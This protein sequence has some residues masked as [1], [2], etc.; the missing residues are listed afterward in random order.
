MEPLA[1]AGLI[2]RCDDHAD[3]GA[4]G[5]PAGVFEGEDDFVRRGG[6][7][8][9]FLAEGAHAGE[10]VSRLHLA[11]EQRL[12]HSGEDLVR[13]RSTVLKLDGKGQH[14]RGVFSVTAQLLHLQV[15]L[16]SG[17]SHYG[18]LVKNDAMI[19]D[20]EAGLQD[21]LFGRFPEVK[22]VKVKQW[23]KFGAVLVNGKRQ[24]RHDHALVP[25]DRVEVRTQAE[26]KAASLLPRAI[27]LIYEDETILV[28][29]KPP[30]LL[31]IAS[32]AEQERTAYAFLMHYV[33]GGNPRSSARVWIVHRL[34][35]ETSGLMIFAKSEE[36]KHELQE[37]WES[38]KKRY[39]AVVEGSPP[40]EEG[41][42]RSFLDERN[43]HHV[44]SVPESEHT[45]HAITHYKVVRRNARY[46]LVQLELETGRRHQIR[47]QMREIGCPVVGDLKYGAKSNAAGRLA[48]HSC[49]LEVEHPATG[50]KVSFE[51][52]LPSALAGIV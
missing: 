17:V 25:G 39:F 34:D 18:I 10:L 14:G 22:R 48:L 33:R 4:R 3:A 26:S 52:P 35:Q 11:R 36:A 44:R 47:V 45:R 51:S 21:F 32:G 16:I 28:I 2:R 6:A 12:A 46:A 24:K 42:L 37:N 40:A 41:T 30:N 27:K 9:E 13:D 5:E 19:V 20:E 31:S 7:D 8:A 50:E 29:D 38:A 49:Y 15:V 43:P 23:L 1:D